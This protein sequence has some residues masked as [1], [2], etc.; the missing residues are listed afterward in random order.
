MSD[1]YEQQFA[2]DF[3]E[4]QQNLDFQNFDNSQYSNY[5]YSPSPSDYLSPNPTQYQPNIFTPAFDQ[6]A[7][8][9]ARH[10]FFYKDHPVTNQFEDEPPLLEELKIYPARIME[11]SMAVLNPF[12]GKGGITDDAEYLFKENDLAGPVAFYL[13]LAF[14]LFISDTRKDVFG[15]V[16]GLSL[17][18]VIFMYILLQLM[19]TTVNESN[20]YITLS[21]VASILGY[22]VLPLVWLSFIGIFFSLN[23]K[24]GVM[25]ASSAVFLSTSAS[26]RI[27][28]LMTNDLNQRYL[29][30]Y[31]CALVY[32]IFALL[33]LF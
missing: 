29:I 5:A 9:A 1:Q 19:C 7:S 3:A 16:Y 25:L 15:Y 23:N 14:C 13:A 26:S 22:S 21:S 30:A 27:F 6:S 24:T 17:I 10:E 2:Y 4:Y 18:S 28:C 31:P 32:V 20:N 11:K 33:V 12:K 8:S